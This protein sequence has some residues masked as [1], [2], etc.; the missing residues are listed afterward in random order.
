[1]NNRQVP[2]A[3]GSANG[4]PH[5]NATDEDEGT[6]NEPLPSHFHVFWNMNLES[7]TDPQTTTNHILGQ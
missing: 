6:F 7:K 5:T 2:L 1:M 4:R 3:H